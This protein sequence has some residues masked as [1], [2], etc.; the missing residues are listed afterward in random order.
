MVTVIVVARYLLTASPA[1]L[2]PV[3]ASSTAGLLP[4]KAIKEWLNR[5]LF[6]SCAQQSA[7]CIHDRSIKPAEGP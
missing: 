3:S 1:P 5:V 4:F 7:E 2:K 6:L